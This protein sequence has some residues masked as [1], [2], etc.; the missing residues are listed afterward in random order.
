MGIYQFKREQTIQAPLEKVWD[1]ISSPSNLKEITP[2]YMGFDIISEDLPEKMYPGMIVIYTVRPLAG[3]PLTWAT[4][5]TQVRELE[6]FVDEQR[7]GPYT[8]WHHEHFIEETSDG[9]LMKD[10]VTYQPPLGWIGDIA[11]QWVI[12]AKLQEIF[13]YRHKAVLR[14]FQ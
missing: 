4:E 11:N 3:I 10:I 5:I 9:T 13:D 12:K 1:F 7:A 2:D 14:I 8:I 6:Y